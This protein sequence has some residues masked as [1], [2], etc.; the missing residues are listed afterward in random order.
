MITSLSLL[1]AAGLQSGAL[2]VS[3]DAREAQ[4]GLIHTKETI[5]V[6]AGKFTLSYPKWIPG[7]HR[8]NGPIDN[9][10]NL[11]FRA[12][13]QLLTWRRDDVEMFHFVV[14]VPEG[15]TSISAEFDD[16]AQ[17]NSSFTPF[18]ARLPWNR[19][20]LYPTG[21]KSDDVQVSASVQLPAGWRMATPLL[22]EPS[23]TD[24][25]EF[26]TVSLTEFVDSPGIA[27][28]NFKRIMAGPQE[29][30]DAFGDT[31]EAVKAPDSTVDHFKSLIVEANTLF[32]AH[33]YRKYDF[34]LSLS[35][36]GAFN[37][38]E[39]HE[40]SEDGTGLTGLTAPDQ[41]FGLGELVAH[42][43][44]HS[45][46][47]KYRRP[48]GL[49]TPDYDEPMKGQLLWVYEGMTQFWGEVLATRSG[50]A[51]PQE[52]EDML[53]NK[54]AYL[55][56]RAGRTW[57]TVEDTAISSQML[58]GG[59]QTWISSRRAQ[60]Y[61]D[62]AVPMWLEVDS[63][64]RSQTKGQKSLEDFCRLFHGGQSGPPEVK[65]YSFDDVVQGLNTVCPYD[66]ATLLTTRMRSLQPQLSTAGLENDGWKL[67]FTE[68]PGAAPRRGRR[69]A[70]GDNDAFYTIGARIASTGTVG[71][72]ILTMPAG[73][74]G[75]RPGMKIVGVNGLT[76]SDDNFLAALKSKTELDLVADY[77]GE[78]KTIH[79]KYSGGP[80]YPHLVRDESKPD[81]LSD[82]LKPLAP[83][84][85]Q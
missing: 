53:A 37:G 28:V 4:F 43:F 72:L 7:T 42:E 74:A 16:A 14:D 39:H 66:W 54:L 22:K 21:E 12:G 69:A 59:D 6:K 23:T 44:T 46:N 38:L 78:L 26:P 62:E 50:F 76:W 32:G 71:D 35:N 52:Y 27:G 10:I 13:A 47:G 73:A 61:Y 79:V 5:P 11:S 70:G 9:M 30:V 65:P 77:G 83:A 24:K 29:E 18:I 56:Y 45:W 85:T 48:A 75:V 31:P 49:A 8:A 64:I 63:I 81:V 40:C 67:V 60:D 33:H 68:Q 25:V 58:R 19:Y 17:P 15:V 57:R 51:T 80:M 55:Q 84:K 36:S 20:V 1:F 41:L 3:I 2:T 82:V 34:L